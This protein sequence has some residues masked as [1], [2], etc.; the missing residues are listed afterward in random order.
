M[1][2]AVSHLPHVLANVLVAPGRGRCPSEGE[3]LPATGPSFRD[4]TRVAG[5]S[6]AIW[7]DIYLAN[8]RRAGRAAIDDAIAR[9]A[10]VRAALAPATATRSPR[11]NDGAARGPPAPA[12]GATW[13]AARCTSCA[14]SV[15]NRPGVDRRDR[16][17]AR[18]RRASTSSTWRCIPA[19]DTVEGTV[20]L[21]IAGDADGA[22]GGGAARRARA[23][24]GARVNA[25]RFEPGGPLRGTVV[26]AGRQVA[27][28]P[29][30]AVRRDERRA[31]ADH[32]LPRR[33]GHAL[34]A[35]RRAGARARWW[36]S[37]TAR[38][39]SAAPGLRAPRGRHG[40]IDVGNAGTLM[41]LLPGLARGPGGRRVDAG[42]RRVDP[43]APGRP[44]RR[45]AARDGRR[46]GGARRA[47]P[48]V[49]RHGRATC[50]G[51]STGCRS[52]P[53]R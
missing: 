15:P 35:A 6:T 16:A 2:A 42:R 40:A 17:R 3:R 47:L 8:A 29:R 13:P 11:W 45:A 19:P 41:R 23:A 4:A 39:W 36:R 43:P 28:A 24:G 37:A 44:R 12:G 49:H 5:A 25:S 7:R 9:L 21:W 48:A 51:S 32:E 46:D 53:R 50:A 22:R 14:S 33:R 31:G 18:P 38:S 30:R 1:M 52:R 10:A 27:V 34:D 20:A 26:A